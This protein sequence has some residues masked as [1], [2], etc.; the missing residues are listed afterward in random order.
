MLTAEKVDRLATWAGRAWT[1]GTMA[2]FW[3]VIRAANESEWVTFGLATAAMVL[4]QFAVLTLFAV[5]QGRVGE[6]R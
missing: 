3:I 1:I 2:V 6:E 5:A 4:F